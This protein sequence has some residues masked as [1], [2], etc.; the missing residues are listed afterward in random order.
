[1]QIYEEEVMRTIVNCVFAVLLCSIVFLRPFSIAAS[2]LEG[3][4]VIQ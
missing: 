2:D 4:T 3:D 1:M